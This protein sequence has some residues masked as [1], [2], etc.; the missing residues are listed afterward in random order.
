M[1]FEN[2]FSLGSLIAISF[3][4]ALTINYLKI[5]FKLEVR[6]QSHNIN[7]NN[8]TINIYEL[9]IRNNKNFQHYR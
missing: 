2:F 5:N 6:N 9:E 4:L 8:N 7:G 3:S 1:L